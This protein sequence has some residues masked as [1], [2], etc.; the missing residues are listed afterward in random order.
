MD[1]VYIGTRRRVQATFK[2]SASPPVA[3]DPTT[4]VFHQRSPLG[5]R[6]SY[7]YVTNA[8]V[9][10]TA[11]GV[12]HVDVTPTEPGVWSFRFEGT[13]TVTAVDEVE[14]EVLA[15]KAKLS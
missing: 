3:A 14:I 6:T 1:K 2:N 12:Y 11:T 7:T 8:E 4:I 13:G 15:S 10:R 9:V 5:V